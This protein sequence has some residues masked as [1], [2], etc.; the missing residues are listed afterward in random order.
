MAGLF[1][2][3]LTQISHSQKPKYRCPRC[4]TQTCSLACYQR[5]Q[6]RASCSGKRYPAAYVKKSQWATPTGIDHDYNY[7]KGVERTIDG[8]S[9]NARQRGI[10]LE[11]RSSKGVARAWNPES[12]L[13][14][15]LRRNNITVEHAPI[16][17]SRQRSNQTRTTKSGSIMWTVEFINQTGQHDIHHQCLESA[18]LEDIY[19][20]LQAEK[21]NAEKRRL[22]SHGKPQKNQ[23]GV[24][25][26]RGHSQLESNRNPDEEIVRQEA[27][28]LQRIKS[29]EESNTVK[30]VFPEYPHLE[31]FDHGSAGDAGT[32]ADSASASHPKSHIEEDFTAGTAADNVPSDGQLRTLSEPASKRDTEDVEDDIA[33]ERSSSPVNIIT[34]AANE[35]EAAKQ[36]LAPNASQQT[37]SQQSCPEHGSEKHFYLLKPATTS[38]SHVLIPLKPNA[39]LTESLQNQTLQ[40][41]PTIYVLPD[42]LESLRSDFILE[43]DYLEMV[44]KQDQHRQSQADQKDVDRKPQ[45]EG[46][47]DSALDANDIL[48]M[49]R[50]DVT[51]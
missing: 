19:Y 31:S 37:F 26:K 24:K 20:G 42:P 10:G 28:S 4:K 6:Q 48:A 22:N 11:T 8:A 46:Q 45:D 12:A 25:R 30:S 40:E 34:D 43:T 27:E 47:G 3:S 2:R 49:L 15:Y 1:H 38:A 7:L 16:G 14:K 36:L 39:S 13:S 29:E 32:I 23:H 50:R 33:S 21:R 18:S 44:A 5:H 17:M 35:Q 9:T 51:T 41:Y